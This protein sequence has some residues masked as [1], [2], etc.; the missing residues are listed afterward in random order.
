MS[1]ST[2]NSPSDCLTN[3]TAEQQQ[4]IDILHQEV[5]AEVPEAELACVVAEAREEVWQDG[6]V[7]AEEYASLADFYIFLEGKALVVKRAGTQ[8]EIFR[9]TVTAPS[10]MGEMSLLS[11]SANGM[12]V[13]A[14]GR[15]RG[16]RVSEGGFW[17]LLAGCPAFRGAVLKEFNFRWRGHAAMRSQQERLLTLGSMTSG[18]MHELN[19][20]G[21][22][23]RRAASQLRDNLNRMHELARGFSEY[24][25]SPE[26]RACLTNL[27]ERVLRVSSEVC[28]DSLQQS[29]REEELGSWMDE[30]GIENA[31]SLAPTMVA[32]GIGSADLEC[33]AG[34]FP[35]TELQAP[36]EWLEATASSMQQVSLV[37]ESVSRVHDLAK[38]VKTYVH[39]GQGGQQSV[40]VN[41]SIHATL[42]L[43]KHKFREKQ[44][45]LEKQFGANLP[46]LTCV[47]SGLNQV[48]TNLLDNAIDAVPEHGHI[49]VRTWQ[50]NE[51]VLVGIAD[52]GSGIPES[53]QAHIF[54]PF[55]TTKPAG[56]GTGMGLG[57][58]QRIVETYNGD[59]TLHSQ[60]GAT[61]FIVRI[62]VHGETTAQ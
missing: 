3:R 4:I 20:P 10:F 56:V 6:E 55:Y 53:E 8:N 35:G 18:L 15:V 23:A 14:V 5:F 40:S 11:Q 43:L 27:Q 13:T 46:P 19:N 32:S 51:D 44:I 31:W 16:L 38:A 41:D 57:I 2:Y 45:G 37:E 1:T 52:D 60:P 29:D 47:C 30:H 58:T 48:W 34:V 21:A 39:E 24:G 7:L 42:V 36:L 54:E 26:Q 9:K 33:L 50:E 62:P 12:G 22:A 25:H 61:E 59:I 49:T 17:N 28:M